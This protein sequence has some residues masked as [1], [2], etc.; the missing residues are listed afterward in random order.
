MSTPPRSNMPPFEQK[1]F[2]MSTTITAVCAVLTVMGAGIAS[3]IACR[4]ELASLSFTTGSI[5]TPMG[6]VRVSLG[7]VPDRS[8]RRGSEPSVG[9]KR[10]ASTCGMDAVHQD[11]R[12]RPQKKGSRRGPPF[13]CRCKEL[14]RLF[15]GGWLPSPFA[16]WQDGRRRFLGPVQAHRQINGAVWRG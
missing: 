6:Q 11:L 15:D 7:G 2:C 8:E 5:H 16:S 12:F 10:G 9:G 14:F 1:S 13:F 4:A 3:M